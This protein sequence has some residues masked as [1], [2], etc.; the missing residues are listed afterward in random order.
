MSDKTSKIFINE[1][2]QF[3]KNRF[4]CKDDLILILETTN[5]NEFDFTLDQMAFKAKYIKGL[6]SVVK[7]ASGN[8]EIKN[9]AQINS[10]LAANLEKFRG[11]LLSINEKMH[12]EI[13]KAFY[14]NYLEISGESFANLKKLIDEFSLIKIF[15]N[16]KKRE[17]T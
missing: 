5:Q 16:H 1:A 11:C 17:T 4:E 7:A 15:L 13:R 10:E 3:S 2:E 12:D 6:M 8:P 9:T 14:K